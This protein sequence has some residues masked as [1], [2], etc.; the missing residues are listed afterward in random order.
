MEG[1]RFTPPEAITP[2]I[3]A[4]DPQNMTIEAPLTQESYDMLWN[5]EREQQHMDNV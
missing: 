5:Q 1:R 3:Q 2:V 4:E